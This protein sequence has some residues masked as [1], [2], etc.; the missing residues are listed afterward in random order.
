MMAASLGSSVV[1]LKATLTAPC[2]ASLLRRSMSRVRSV[3]PDMAM[4]SP[5]HPGEASS[6]RRSRGASGL[7]T[8]RVS[9]SKPQ[10]KPS[11]S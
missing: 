5:A 6:D 9:K 3:T 2:R 11:V 4:A 1:T 8:I 7:A 10:E